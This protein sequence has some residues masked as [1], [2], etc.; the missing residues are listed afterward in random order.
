MKK[1]N[2]IITDQALYYL[3][4]SIESENDTNI[5]IYV[6]VAYPLTKDAYVNITYCKKTDLN[7]EDTELQFNNLTIYIEKKSVFLLNQSIID[8]KNKQLSINAPNIYTSTSNDVK[9]TKEKIKQLFEN[10]INVIL[11]QHGGFIELIDIINDEKLI[12]K[13]H[14]GCQGCGMIS[15]TLNNYIEKLIKT[16]FPKIKDID[17]I[18]QHDIKNNSYY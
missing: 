3:K 17:D 15:Y 12:V 16:H 1:T 18:T 8:F 4:S 5:I 9:N 2:I 13:F 7:I 6:S 11:S 10:E 14:G